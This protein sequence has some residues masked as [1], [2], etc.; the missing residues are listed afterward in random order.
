M[1]AGTTPAAAMRQNEDEMESPMTSSAVL[2]YRPHDPDVAPVSQAPAAALDL[3][4]FSS[5]AVGDD[6]LGR[7]GLARRL[8]DVLAHPRTETPLTM[9]V[10][11]PPGSGKSQLLRRVAGF[12]GQVGTQDAD[13]GAAR[14]TGSAAVSAH[15]DLA[16]GGDPAH[17]VALGLLDALAPDHAGFA[18]DAL[19]A[20]GNPHEAA[21]RASERSIALRRTL[22]GER[23][24]LDDF[25]AR[26]ARLVETVL[27]D[28]AGTRVDGYARANRTRIEA[29]L[30]AFGLPA[31]DPLRTYKEFVRETSEVPGA[32][33][34]VGFALRSLWSYKGQGSLVVIAVLLFA[35]A[36]AASAG[37]GDEARLSGWLAGLGDRFAFLTDWERAHLDW[38]QPISQA[39]AALG[40][41]ALVV[42][43]LR[44][45]RFASP[46]LKGGTLLKADLGERRRDIDGL[47]AQQT[48]RIDGLVAEADIASR[49]AE[50]AER[51]L[52]GRGRSGLTDHGVALAGDLFGSGRSPALAAQSFC[53]ALSRAMTD[54]SATSGV[55]VP[56]RILVTVDGLDQL[57]GPAAG[58]ALETLHRLLARPG[59]ATLVAVD[60]HHIVDAL[61]ATDPALAAARLDRFVQMSYDL[62]ADAADSTRLADLLLAPGTTAPAQMS[63]PGRGLPADRALQRFE[64]DMLRRLAPFAGST[65][66][67]VKRFL[68]AYRLASTDPRIDTASPAVLGCLA[69]ALALDGT[70]AGASLATFEAEAARGKVELDKE[71]DLGR[72]FTVVHEAV[73]GPFSASDARLGVLVARSYGR[74]G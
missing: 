66:R 63:A 71:S 60:R 69:W 45:I 37:S 67:A 44:A 51:R 18:E 52:G 35:L 64:V 28:T 68:N 39:A 72:A 34:R 29:R 61:G 55:D 6:R 23:K 49:N 30:R 48:R 16:A 74:N 54:R 47:I 42:V 57:P 12:V 11:G 41:L 70:P 9:A 20:G 33:S 36:W 8:A 58:A 62:G 10:F 24:I 17:T 43:V 3:P 65:P 46:V 22:D 4:T 53:D 25:G 40:V 38:L 19:H 59:F 7:D 13:G 26:R 50:Q 27:F 56:G 2:A 32:G 21:K 73:G 31:T 14:S 5:D 15:V 1:Q